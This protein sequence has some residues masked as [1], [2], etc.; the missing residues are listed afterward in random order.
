MSNDAELLT[1]LSTSPLLWLTTTLG[2]WLASDQIATAAGRHPL[3]NPLLISVIVI[4]LVLEATGT[5]YAT[6]SSGAQ[7]IQF[8]IGPAVVAIAVPLFKNWAIVKQN[9]VPILTALFVGCITAI[10]A[11][12][13]IAR[14]LHLPEIITMSLA[15]KSA[16]TGAAM[17][18]SK[19]IGGEP[20]MTATFTVTTS[21]IA[22]VTL[23]SFM[24]LLRVK[25]LAAIG[26]SAGLSGHSVGT[27]RAFQVDP[28]AG[29]FAGI[30][31]CLNAILTGLIMPVLLAVLP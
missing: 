12:V 18:I 6:Y 17:A 1:W 9:A 26:F 29:T 11:T 16:T 4:G 8:M 22:A 3:A 21:I 19:S 5:S 25:D 10:A 14:A 27:A 31:L 23:V 2:V 13:L 15:P 7:F 28:I 20:A 24:R 30:A